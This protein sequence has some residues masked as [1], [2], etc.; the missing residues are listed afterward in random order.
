MDGKMGGGM[1]RWDEVEGEGYEPGVEQPVTVC[2]VCAM[3]AL[4]TPCG[5]NEASKG[6]V[7]S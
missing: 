2:V 5:L 3:E 1:C 7:K 4:H 6:F